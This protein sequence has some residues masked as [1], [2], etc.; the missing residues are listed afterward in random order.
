MRQ[1]LPASPG[2]HISMLDT[3]CLILDLDALEHNIN[4]LAAYYKDSECKLRPH[5]KNHRSPDI[6]W[7]QIRAGGTVNGVCASKVSEAEVMVQ[8]GIPQVLIANQVVTK[9]K[10]DRL[11]SL[12]RSADM[13][14][15]VDSEQNVDD[16]D[17][18]A[19]SHNVNLGVILE[20]D[21]NI[22]RS[23]VQSIEDAVKLA[24]RVSQS[25]GLDFRG[26][27]S[28]QSIDHSQAGDPNIRTGEAKR[29]I[30]HCLEVAKAVIAAGFPCE[31]VSTGETWSYDVA[32]ASKG[33]TEIQGGSYITKDTSHNFFPEFQQAIKVLGTIISTPRSKTAIGDIGVK[34]AT[35]IKGNPEVEGYPNIT[36]TA[37][38]AEHTL[39]NDPNQELKVGDQYQLIVAMQDA[40]V[41]RWDR[42]IGVRNNVVERVIEI[43]ARGR[44]N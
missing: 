10:I 42:Y 44:H 26:I 2:T 22:H 8:A 17:A 31:I 24:K 36:V 35:Q 41:N 6:A 21:T 1:P 16:L 28:H 29:T 34:A 43:T 18:A 20:I 37:L 7:M 5:V 9:A 40:L 38:Q 11:C 3:P 30:Q 19:Q 12:C 25:S 13:I 14:V 4:Y 27:M 23:G 32:R 39:L 33:V 15:A